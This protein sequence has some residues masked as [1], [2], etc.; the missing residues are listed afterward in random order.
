[1][2]LIT[3]YK[4]VRQIVEY[5]NILPDP[6]VS[7]ICDDDPSKACEC[8]KQY[9]VMR[10]NVKEQPENRRILKSIAFGDSTHYMQLQAADLLAW[11]LRAESLYE[12]F[13]EDY[14]LRTL[15]PEFRIEAPEFK[16]QCAPAFYG[17]VQLKQFEQLCLERHRKRK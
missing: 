5:A 9:D 4:V 6:T 7:L 1:M 15:L 16:L 8:Y 17:P 11:I 12:F 2:I 3:F 14:N 10:Q 13:G